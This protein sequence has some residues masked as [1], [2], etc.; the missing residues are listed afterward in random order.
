[1]QENCPQ[2]SGVHF[3][4]SEKERMLFTEK[5]IFSVLPSAERLLCIRR[6][7]VIRATGS[8]LLP[9]SRNIKSTGE[10]LR[11]IG[12]SHVSCGAEFLIASHVSSREKKG[13]ISVD[14]SASQK[15]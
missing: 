1:M 2:V 4:T 10:P 13:K 12:W 9:D 5:Q 6:S 15:K 3:W 11:P 14:T 7:K 8:R